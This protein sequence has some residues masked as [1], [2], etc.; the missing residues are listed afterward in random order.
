[1][2]KNYRNTT[3]NGFRTASKPVKLA[4]LGW[5]PTFDSLFRSLA[6]NHWIPGRVAR[7]DR[8]SYVVYTESGPLQAAISGK[9]R[10]EAG[11]R[12]ELPAVGD[13]VALEPRAAEG[14]AT[15]HAVLPRRSAFSRQ[16]AGRSSDEQIVAANVS[17]VFIVCGLDGDYNVRRIERYL[18]LSFG[19]GATPIV[20]L[21][22]ADLCDDV[23]ARISEVQS[24]APGTPI[25]AVIATSAIPVRR[26]SC[27]HFSLDALS[28]YL[29]TGSTTALLGSSGVGK[30]TLLN[31]LLGSRQQ[32]TQ[33]V[34]AGD[35]KGR[36]TTT[37]RELFLL[38]QGGVVIDTPG[39]REL[40]MWTDEAGLTGSFA[41]IDE[42]T[43]TCRFANCRHK[44]EPGCAV[45]AAIDDGTLEAARFAS[46]G[47]LQREIHYAETRNDHRAQAEK[48]A[49]WIKIHKAARQRT[50]ARKKW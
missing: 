28:P 32:E 10:Y 17:H 16:S 3:G 42:L 48:K 41:D 27:I 47:K 19:S 2:T 15:I 9:L 40:Q 49:K 12:S 45:R 39:M 37:H 21:N 14:R 13:W 43:D 38:P 8:L 22:K 11:A 33:P 6:C 36:H 23:G 31:S 30:S 5:T 20:V 29:Q 44:G 25:H 35:G 26:D 1:M 24:V 50:K 18:T 46:Y 4:D 7:E 34:R